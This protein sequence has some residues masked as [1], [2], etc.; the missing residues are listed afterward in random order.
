MTDTPDTLVI[1][2][3]ADW[4]LEQAKGKTHAELGE[5][6]HDLIARVQDTGRK[7]TITLTVTVEPMKKDASLLV[8]S[9]EIKIKLPEYDRPA[10]VFYADRNGNLTRD[11]P[12]QLSFESLREVPPPPG[13]NA[14]TGEVTPNY[15]G[16]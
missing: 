7:G 2:P 4:L 14:A 1:R 9:D 13:V 16:A 11:N 10:G 12:D 8:V 6:L 3:F 5:G 15:Q